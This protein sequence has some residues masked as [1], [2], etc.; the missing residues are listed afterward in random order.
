MCDWHDAV[1][2]VFEKQIAKIPKD[3]KPDWEQRGMGRKRRE[4]V[5]LIKGV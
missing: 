4:Y 3:L 1:I 5:I 2:F